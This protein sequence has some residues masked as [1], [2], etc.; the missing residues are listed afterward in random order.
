M[1]KKIEDQE[2]TIS[3][4]ESIIQGSDVPMNS[5]NL[6]LIG[7]AWHEKFKHFFLSFE[8]LRQ[9]LNRTDTIGQQLSSASDHV[10]GWRSELSAYA[11]E[12]GNAAV[13]EINDICEEFLQ[14]F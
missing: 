2:E 1:Q 9:Y 4:V 6:N 7:F 3:Q 5:S 12:E 11:I 10:N 14:Q 8:A 13:E